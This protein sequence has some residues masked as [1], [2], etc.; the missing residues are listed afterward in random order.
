MIGGHGRTSLQR[1]EA[2]EIV[3]W[4]VG[5]YDQDEIDSV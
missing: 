2:D 4:K 5:Y 3:P 1:L